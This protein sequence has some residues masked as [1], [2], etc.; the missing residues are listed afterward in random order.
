MASLGS[1]QAPGAG[2]LAG[3]MVQAAQNDK[4]GGSTQLQAQAAIIGGVVSAALGVAAIG[5]GGSLLVLLGGAM[6]L[7]GAPV[8]IT[9]SGIFLAQGPGA[10]PTNYSNAMQAVGMVSSPGSLLGFTVGAIAGGTYEKAAELG[11]LGSLAERALSLNPATDLASGYDVGTFA[12][13]A[14]DVFTTAPQT[15]DSGGGSGSS[16]P[17]QGS[18]AG[19]GTRSSGH[20]GGRDYGGPIGDRGPTG[21]R[22]ADRPRPEVERP[23]PEPARPDPPKKDMDKPG[24]SDRGRE[25]PKKEPTFPSLGRMA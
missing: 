19:T 2:S 22:R 1:I 10:N 11:R 16:R 15:R 20:G 9:L 4:L 25:S 18:G 23:R 3:G 21:D 17:G 14:A 6:A 8:S 12:V 13:D 5:S 7:A 24:P